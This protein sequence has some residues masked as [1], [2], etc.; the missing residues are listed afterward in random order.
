M[1]CRMDGCVV[2]GLLFHFIFR[3]LNLNRMFENRQIYLYKEHLTCKSNIWFEVDML[4]ADSCR[5]VESTDTS[6]YYLCRSP[7]RFLKDFITL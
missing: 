5:F 7:H 6:L 1:S 4:I 2:Y 3:D